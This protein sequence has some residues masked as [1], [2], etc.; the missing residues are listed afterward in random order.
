MSLYILFK[1]IDCTAPRVTL[2]VNCGL[3]MMTCPWSSLFGTNVPSDRGVG[4]GGT[5]LRQETSVPSVQFCY[6]PNTMLYRKVCLKKRTSVYK[7]FHHGVI[8]WGE[9]LRKQP[10]IWPNR[11]VSPSMD[12]MQ[13]LTTK[14]CLGK[15]HNVKTC[16]CAVKRWGTKI[17]IQY[18][19][20]VEN[21]YGV[22][23]VSEEI[24][25]R[26]SISNIL[27]CFGCSVFFSSFLF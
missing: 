12:R 15:A 7:D 20:V 14:R 19:S 4:G 16:P 9:N 13:L 26:K 27:K 18:Y 2:D 6:E 21:K 25:K 1:P 11:M 23:S 22:K 5:I 8:Y 10:F 3:W 17:Y 24:S